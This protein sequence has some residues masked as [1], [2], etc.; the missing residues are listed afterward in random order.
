M[1]R[2]GFAHAERL[3]ISVGGQDYQLFGTSK[4]DK[5]GLI[6]YS[7]PLGGGMALRLVRSNRCPDWG[8]GNQI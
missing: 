4:Q 8:A 1:D 3:A 2:N 7:A 5:L 6:E